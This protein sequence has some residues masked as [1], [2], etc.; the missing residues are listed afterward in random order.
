MQTVQWQ[1]QVQAQHKKNEASLLRDNSAPR[2]T[3]LTKAVSFFFANAG[4]RKLHPMRKTQLSNS[5]ASQE[6]NE[7]P[8]I[9]F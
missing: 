2:Q 4:W 8:P 3:V 9:Q 6:I 7:M 1:S 5:I